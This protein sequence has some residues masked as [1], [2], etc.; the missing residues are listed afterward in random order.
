M[1]TSLSRTEPI[2]DCML[3]LN[4]LESITIGLRTLHDLNII[5]GNLSPSNILMDSQNE[6]YISDYCLNDIRNFRLLPK[7]HFAY[8]SPEQ[9]IDKEVTKYSDV[10][11]LGCLLYYLIQSQ[12]LFTGKNK[13]EIQDNILTIDIQQFH[14][15]DI[16][17]S[18]IRGCL[19]YN[20]QTRIKLKEIIEMIHSIN[21]IY[22]YFFIL[23]F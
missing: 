11:S 8:L 1:S 3:Q 7:N 9:L 21:I 12:D 5:H 4:I 2:S 16:Y 18:I 23:L 17:N 15:L 10:W 13:E 22:F 20:P 6:V 19:H 14:G